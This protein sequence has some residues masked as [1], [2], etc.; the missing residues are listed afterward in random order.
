MKDRKN[1]K[2]YKAT[3]RAILSATKAILFRVAPPLSR[4]KTEDLFVLRSVLDTLV[5]K[6]SEATYLGHKKYVS[7]ERWSKNALAA[8]LSNKNSYT[9]TVA[10][11]HVRSR[12]SIIDNLLAASDGK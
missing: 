3:R 11:E 12:K 10:L 1:R 5:W 8:Y 9:K 2:D 4:S 7:C 6:Y